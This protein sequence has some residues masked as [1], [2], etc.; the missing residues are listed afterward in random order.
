MVACFKDP[1]AGSHVAAP[2]ALL[3]APSALAEAAAE[4]LDTRLGI[5]NTWFGHTTLRGHQVRMHAVALI[6]IVLWLQSLRIVVVVH[7]CCTVTG[8][9]ARQPR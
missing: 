1:V 8:E 6:H 7:C 9:R 3:S 5:L 2:S 4:P